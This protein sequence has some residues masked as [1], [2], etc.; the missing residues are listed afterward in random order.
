[1]RIL[2]ILLLAIIYLM[3]QSC[4][5]TSF[6]S[7]VTAINGDTLTLSNHK[8]FVVQRADTIKVGQQLSFTPVMNKKSNKINSTIVKNK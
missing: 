7:T 6:N 3:S 5:S 2:I 4:K 8:K 1:M